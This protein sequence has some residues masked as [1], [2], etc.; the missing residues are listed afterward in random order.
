MVAA[1][2]VLTGRRF[3]SLDCSLEEGIPVRFVGGSFLE[4]AML[5]FCP[6]VVMPNI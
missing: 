3:Q 4:K 1:A 2:T 6:A 5:A